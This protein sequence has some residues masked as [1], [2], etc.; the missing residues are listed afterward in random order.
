[1]YVQRVEVEADAQSPAITAMVPL[2]RRVGA[3]VVQSSVS[4]ER[5]GREE[6]SLVGSR[7]EVRRLETLRA[8]KSTAFRMSPLGAKM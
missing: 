3:K 5:K 7:A 2:R 1:V 6:V 4:G 8:R